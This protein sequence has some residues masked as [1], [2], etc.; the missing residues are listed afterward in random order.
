MK[1]RPVL[2]L[3]FAAVLVHSAPVAANEYEPAL[4]DLAQSQ[5]SDWV[6][7]GEIANAIKA[8]NSA[9]SGLSDAEIV[10]LDQTWRNEVGAGSSPMIDE[11]LSRPSSQSLIALQEASEGLVTEVFI[12][13]NRGLNVAQSGVTSDYWQGD[14]AKWQ[15]TFPLG[16]GAMHFGEVEFDEST[17]TYQTQLSMAVTDPE[18][19]RGHRCRHIRDRYRLSGI[20]VA[21]AQARPCVAA[22]RAALARA[23]QLVSHPPGASWAR[24]YCGE[25]AQGDFLNDKRKFGAAA[26]ARTEN[27]HPD[28]PVSG[29]DHR[30]DDNGGDIP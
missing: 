12:M 26:K 23:I 2:A 1:L 29:R 30:R 6:A 22:L 16:A 10:A 27:W 20:S 9:H 4:R 19:E 7:S 21:I 17:Q 14:E 5:L 15:E 13:D 3:G 28:C 18:Y 11:V 8:Q 24:F 25:P